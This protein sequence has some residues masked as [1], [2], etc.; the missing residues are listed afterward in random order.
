MLLPSYW[1][2]VLHCVCGCSPPLAPG[3]AHCMP[4]WLFCC[5]AALLVPAAALATAAARPS[6][7]ACPI[8]APLLIFCPAG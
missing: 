2:W 3:V 6:T 4:L 5:S 1:R 7:L 8:T